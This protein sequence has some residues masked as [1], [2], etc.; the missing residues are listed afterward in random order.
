MIE[1]LAIFREI[2]RSRFHFRRSNSNGYMN[3]VAS[4]LNMNNHSGSVRRSIR[5]DER[6]LRSSV[7]RPRPGRLGGQLESIRIIVVNALAKLIVGGIKRAA[8]PPWRHTKPRRVLIIEPPTG[9]KR[10]T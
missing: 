9:V 4:T 8:M 7:R 5:S 3:T 1:I 6:E 2:G 10:E